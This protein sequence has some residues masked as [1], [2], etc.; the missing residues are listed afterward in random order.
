MQHLKKNREKDFEL[1]VLENPNNPKEAPRLDLN[2]SPERI[3]L[4]LEEIKVP[5]LKMLKE[6]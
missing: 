1:D 5:P 2:I 3:K 4:L 6:K